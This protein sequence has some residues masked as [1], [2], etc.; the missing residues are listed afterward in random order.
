MTFPAP[1]PCSNPPLEQV[2]VGRKQAVSGDQER[3]VSCPLAVFAECVTSRLCLWWGHHIVLCGWVWALAGGLLSVGD[4]SGSPGEP[5]GAYVRSFC[6]LASFLLLIQ[7][8]FFL[9]SFTSPISHPEAGVKQKENSQGWGSQCSLGAVR[10]HW[11]LAQEWPPNLG[12]LWGTPL[13]PLPTSVRTLQLFRI[14]V[15]SLFVV[16]PYQPVLLLEIIFK[17]HHPPNLH[18]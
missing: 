14:K 10:P 2:S 9:I 17:W 13:P 1:F 16:A 6:P 7:N 15:L 12:P 8:D 4:A 5:H 18:K 11:N 3:R